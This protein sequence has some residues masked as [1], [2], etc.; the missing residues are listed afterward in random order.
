MLHFTYF[1]QLFREQFMCQVQHRRQEKKYFYYILLYYKKIK[2]KLYI[3]FVNLCFYQFK[4]M[5][6]F[7]YSQYN[8]ILYIQIFEIFNKFSILV[9]FDMFFLLSSER[10]FIIIRAINQLIRQILTRQRTICNDNHSTEQIA[11]LCCY[12]LFYRTNCSSN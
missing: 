3:L 8:T 12:L 6:T 11:S 1:V 4:I 9:I 10:Y 5:Y 2:Q 7:L